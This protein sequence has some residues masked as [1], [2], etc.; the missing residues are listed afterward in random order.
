MAVSVLTSSGAGIPSSKKQKANNVG[1][2]G[3]YRCGQH[4]FKV[5]QSMSQPEKYRLQTSPCGTMVGINVSGTPF[6]LV[7][8]KFDRKQTF[9]TESAEH[10]LI[11]ERRNAAL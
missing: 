10:L 5:Y 3:G 2:Y 6:K 11:I 1:R 4:S 9:E 8:S 7:C